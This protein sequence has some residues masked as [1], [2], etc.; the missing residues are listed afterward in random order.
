MPSLGNL[1]AATLL[2]ANAL[3]LLRFVLSL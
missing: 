1:H 2:I 3:S